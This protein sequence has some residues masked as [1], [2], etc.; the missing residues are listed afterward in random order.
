MIPLEDNL[1]FDL[2]EVAAAKR[3]KQI[4]GESRN[5]LIVTESRHQDHLDGQKKMRV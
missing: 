4:E 5:M 3:V 2:K 1:V